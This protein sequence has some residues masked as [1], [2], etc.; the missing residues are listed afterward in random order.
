MSTVTPARTDDRTSTDDEVRGAWRVVAEREVTTRVREKS[1]VYSALFMVVGVVAMVV[2][3]SILGGRPTDY[4]VAVT[5][6]ASAAIVSSASDVV[7]R[8]DDG[9]TAEPREFTSTAAAEKAVRDGDVDAA[10]VAT[11]TGYEV[12]GDEEVDSTLSAALTAVGTSEALQANAERQG[13]DLDELQ[14]GSTVSERLLDPAE[15]D[16]GAR[17]LAAYVFLILFYI[18]AITF[19]MSIAQS[20]V[21]EKESRVVEI[22][23]AAVPIRA[24]LWGK[25]AGNTLLAFA[26][27]LLLAAAGI[28]ALALTGETGLLSSLGPAVGMYVVF[29]VLGFVA[30]AG[31]WAVAGSLASRQEDLQSTTMPGQVLL[32]APYIIAFSAGAGV[33]TVVSMLPIMSAM[34]MPSR[35]AEGGVPVWQIV[36][37]VVVNVVGAVLI[38]RLAARLYERTLMRTER[39]IGFG[40]ALRLSE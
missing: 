32:F 12:V 33:K 25:I 16:A 14:A 34:L 10:L 15:S 8:S 6:Q 20:V 3:T 1:Y 9:S 17:Q 40:E 21:Q 38:V 23:A 26:Q 5:D 22:L 18:T 4:T 2:L 30:L 37:A 28:G 11:E 27:I 13:V 39:K 31:L 7:D 24:M 35:M 36:V 29:F 19:G